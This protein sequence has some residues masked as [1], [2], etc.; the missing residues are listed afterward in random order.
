MPS[1]K[2]TLLTELFI[3]YEEDVIVAVLEE[4][5]FKM[6]ATIECLLNLQ[7]NFEKVPAKNQKPISNP[8]NKT[9]NAN[10][11]G[12]RIQTNIPQNSQK[13]EKELS[14]FENIDNNAYNNNN[15]EQY[16]DPQLQQFEQLQKFC[17][18]NGVDFNDIELMNYY[19]S[20]PQIFNQDQNSVKQATQKF[21]QA[22][23]KENKSS[24]PG[25][26]FDASNSLKN[27][28]DTGYEAKDANKKK[29]IV[30]EENGINNNENG[31]IKKKK[32][33]GDKFKDWFKDVFGKK[34]KEE[35]DKKE[36]ESV[37]IDDESDYKKK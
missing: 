1:S 4:N 23:K 12:N 33:F 36:Y 19:M 26:S 35:K 34:K 2:A 17:I 31:Q 9:S 5:N 14:L 8:T 20:H 6:E 18:E 15:K 16:I 30:I 3:N 7:N 37:A 10:Q 32:S 13:A 27:K 24:T 25:K 28:T 22:P 11:T 29:K 21:Q